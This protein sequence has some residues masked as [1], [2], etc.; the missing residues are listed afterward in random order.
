MILDARADVE[1]DTELSFDLCIIGAGPAGLT[2]ALELASLGI[3]ICVL[4]AGG[5]SF[6]KVSQDFF[7]G[8]VNGTQREEQLHSYRYRRLGGTSTAWGGRCLRYDPIDF[9]RRDYVPDSGWPISYDELTPYYA[10][11]L[12]RCEAG[13]MDYDASSVLPEEVPQMIAGM[14]DGDVISSTL[15]RWSPPTNFGKRY[16]PLLKRSGTTTVLLNAACV[17]LNLDDEHR[18]LVSVSVR[19]GNE[20][21]FLVKAEAFVMAAGGVEVPRLLLASCH[22]VPEGVGNHSDI[23]GRYFMTHIAGRIATAHLDVA[24]DAVA[25]H[26]ARDSQGVYVRRRIAFSEEAQRREHIPNVSV[27]FH[28]PSVDDPAHRNA[29]LSAVF[30]AKHIGSIRRGIPPGLGIVDGDDDQE[31]AA[32]WLRHFRNLVGDLPGLL[33][34]MPRFGYLRYL[35]RRRIPSVILPTKQPVFPM[36]YHAEQSPSRESRVSLA[37][38]RDRYGM[39]RARLDFHVNESDI[40]GVYRVH[41]LI[42]EYFRRHKVGHVQFND[43]DPRAGIRRE[44]R[45]VNG[46]FIGTTRMS[47]DPRTGVVDT[48]CKVFGI[49]NLFISSSAVFPTSSHANPTLTIVALA[50]RLADHLRKRQWTG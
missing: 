21:S 42:D 27:Q 40:D 30:F 47:T 43:P 3:R 25:Q 4:E 22:Q 10:R 14:P 46:H 9:E 39:P 24:S 15:E 1:S 12:E 26:Y 45:A 29:I 36:H 16:R 33:S 49:S 7:R 5:N 13:P 41:T 18:R 17:A 31:S 28:I 20:K 6:S 44:T 34:F 37:G 35:R 2:L 32:L 38:D 11:A 19:A 48:D 50:T 23:V 8:A